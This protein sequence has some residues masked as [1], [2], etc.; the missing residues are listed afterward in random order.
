ME[1]GLEAGRPVRRLVRGGTGQGRGTD[2]EYGEEQGH[3]DQRGVV[4]SAILRTKL[5]QMPALAL[6]GTLATWSPIGELILSK[7]DDLLNS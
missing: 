1:V 2:S 4:A 3:E 5:A 6:K 7:G